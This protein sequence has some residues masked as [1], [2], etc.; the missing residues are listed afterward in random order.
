MG[1]S[2]SAHSA[3]HYALEEI[4]KHRSITK[5]QLRSELNMNEMKRLI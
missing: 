1:P 3:L 4:L 5:Q 2:T